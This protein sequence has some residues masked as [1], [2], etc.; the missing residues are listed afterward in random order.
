M[1][2]TKLNTNSIRILK[3]LSNHKSSS[4]N[5]SGKMR[6]IL[7]FHNRKEFDDAIEILENWKYI[8]IDNETN[9]AKYQINKN[10]IEYLDEYNDFELTSIFGGKRDYA[11]LKFLYQIKEKTYSDAFP[12]SILKHIPAS[13]KGMN[14]DYYLK[15]YIEYDSSLKTYVDIDDTGAISINHLG[16]NY[17]EYLDERK[18]K[19]TEIINQPLMQFFDN[20]NI[21]H[22][23][24]GNTIGDRNVMKSKLDNS[25]N[26][27]EEN[28][29]S[30][31]E[32][33]IWTK[34]NVYVA[35]IAIIVTI[36][37]AFLLRN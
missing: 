11:I 17:F 15:N 13:G 33:L 12:D 20:S 18:L 27:N 1:I 16:Q 7:K 35:I 23:G 28:E 36:V 3:Y 24:D 5:T 37:I 10:G 31:K 9:I 29:E 14:A 6:L 21:T 25:F 30:K 19:E 4:Q 22:I 2:K 8:E 32:S 34:R 26:T